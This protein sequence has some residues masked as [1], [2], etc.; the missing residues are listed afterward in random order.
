MLNPIDLDAGLIM[1]NWV[2]IDKPYCLLYE[3]R[4]KGSIGNYP[5]ALDFKKEGFYDCNNF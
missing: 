5:V 3:S 1:V 4:T 2:L